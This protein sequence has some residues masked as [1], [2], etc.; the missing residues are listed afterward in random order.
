[1]TLTTP[2][3]PTEPS[4]T[5]RAAVEMKSRST[6]PSMIVDGY[7]PSSDADKTIDGKPVAERATL[8]VLANHADGISRRT[9]DPSWLRSQ[10]SR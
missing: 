4:L 10:A 8:D 2:I 7:L 9:F 5:A 6:L 3:A 1:M